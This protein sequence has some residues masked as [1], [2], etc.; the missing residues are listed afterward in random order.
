M[1]SGGY[2]I[3]L[4]RQGYVT[5]VDSAFAGGN[6]P[7]LTGV[8]ARGVC[9]G[10]RISRPEVARGLSVV[11]A[12]GEHSDLLS[13]LSEVNVSEPKN[14]RAI[15]CG[16]VTVELG[17]GRYRL[18]TSRLHQVLLQV[19]DLNMRARRV[20][21]RFSGQVIMDYHEAPRRARKEV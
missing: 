20:D 3:G 13:I 7:C 15:L 16:G 18:K 11:R 4:D 17:S 9:R 10:D 2:I 6:L 21:L 12:F 1:L 19:P 14:P 8:S 5:S